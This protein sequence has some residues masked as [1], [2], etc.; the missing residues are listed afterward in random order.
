MRNHS[1]NS[2]GQ[3]RGTNAFTLLELVLVLACVFFLAVLILPAFGGTTGAKS[4]ALQCLQNQR[5]IMAA[6]LMYT[7]D[8]NDFMPPN[9]DDGNTVSGHNWCPGQAGT[10]GA[11]EYDPDI[12]SD[13]RYSL[14]AVY[15]KGQTGLYQCPA[16]PRPLGRAS[17]SSSK[18]PAY[19]DKFIPPARTVSMSG[20]VGTV[21]ATFKNGGSGHGANQPPV[22]PVD[23]PWLN[24]SHSHKAN[25]PWRT[26]GKISDVVAPTPSKLF[27][28]MDEN[29]LGLN[30]STFSFGMNTAEWIDFPGVAHEM[31]C[32]LAFADGH[33]EIH[34]W[35]DARTR[36]SEPRRTPV[37][38]SPDWLWMTEHTSARAE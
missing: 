10:G 30:D 38:G 12:L 24:N 19:A 25:Q 7:Q 26:Y 28:L 33:A 8:N 29:T 27:V 9:P 6:M 34:K 15:L 20:A 22:Y 18:N 31:G 4:K 17:G 5:Q 23:G 35:A 21:C 16:D 36:V 2:R 37:P 13:E 3:S 32:S 14:L 11:N 1:C